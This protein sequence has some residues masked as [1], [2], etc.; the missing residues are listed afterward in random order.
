MKEDYWLKC[1]FKE[2]GELVCIR[3][4]SNTKPGKTFFYREGNENKEARNP[5]VIR[6]TSENINNLMKL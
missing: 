3:M 2:N 1:G 5:N 6:L 4:L